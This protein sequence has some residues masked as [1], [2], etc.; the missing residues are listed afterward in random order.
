ML[1]G[2]YRDLCEKRDGQWK[3]LRRV[4]IA[5]WAQQLPP[6]AS[7]GELF[8]YLPTAHQGATGPDDPIYG[9]WNVL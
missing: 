5:D 9:D 7:Y 8:G 1:G 4:V 3:V 6:N 2:R